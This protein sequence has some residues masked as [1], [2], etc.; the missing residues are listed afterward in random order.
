MRLRSA[1]D[2]RPGRRRPAGRRATTAPPWGRYVAAVAAELG[3]AAVG[4]DGTVETTVPIG[5]GLSSSAALEVAV[6][7]ALGF[8][9]DAADPGPA[10]PAGRAPRRRACRAGSWTSSTAA[11][12]VDGAALCIDCAALAITPVPLPDD[13]EV[14]V[15]PSGERAGAGRL[16]LRRADGAVRGGRGGRGPVAPGVDRSRGG[17]RRPGRAP[18][19]PPRRHR[20]RAGAPGGRGVRR[21]RRRLGR[22]AHGGQP[23]VPARR[24]RGLDGGARPVGG[25]AVRR[26]RACSGRASPAP[27]SAV[28][29]WPWPGPARSP[30]G[31]WCGPSVGL[32]STSA[33]GGAGRP[34]AER[35][36]PIRR[37]RRSGSCPAAP[38][39]RSGRGRPRRGGPRR[40]RAASPVAPSCGA[41]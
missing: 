30:R 40:H 38:A 4:L 14:V 2:A 16:G 39:R 9:G 18:A 13:V 7:L 32:G 34:C 35:A 29:S 24:L 12:G 5:A 19:G 36:A 21:R 33:A 28:A 1:D 31:G 8:D 22:A 6:A 20:E 11:A 17:H 41:R 15:V 3:D 27:G 26:T 25:T 37:R 23:R 10:V